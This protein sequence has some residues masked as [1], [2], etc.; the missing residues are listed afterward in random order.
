[1]R[2]I[3]D[4]HGRPR[5][6]DVNPSLKVAR[7]LERDPRAP[8]YEHLTPEGSSFIYPPLALLLYRP[9]VAGS[10]EQAHGWLLIANHVVFG[11]IAVLLAIYLAR[12]PGLH[13]WEAALAVP[14]VV[15]YYPLTRALEINQATLVVTFLLGAAWL[16]LAER[17][18]VAAGVALAL[19]SAIKPH[20]VLAL[21]LLVWALPAM[22]TAA[23]A[24]GAALALASVGYAGW[25]NH[26]DYATRVLPALSAGYA[27]YANQSW[28][29]LFNRLYDLPPPTDFVLAPRRISVQ[30]LTLLCGAATYVAALIVAWR[31]RAEAT[32]PTLLLGLAWLT[33]TLVSP[34]SWEHHYAPGLF[35]FATLYAI[36]RS[37]RPSPPWLPLALAIAFVAMAG[38]FEVRSLA[39]LA[40]RL[41]ASYVLAGGLIL[42][43]TCLA[44]LTSRGEHG[45]V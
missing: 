14:A 36:S 21:P 33:T 28:N 44:L 7:R 40:P 26:A 5:F 9:F 45:A 4:I 8:L 18:Q 16:A 38:Y 15:L 1:M 2:S 25:A 34:I 30:G 17:R 19:A 3:F 39:G 23:A 37:S 43:L 32:P 22:V 41:L 31:R 10:E 42:E 6:G 12:Q 35:V 11:G 24:A 20:L 13:P 27:F 29:G